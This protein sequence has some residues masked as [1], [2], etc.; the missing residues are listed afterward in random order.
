[1]RSRIVRIGNSKGIRIPKALLEEAQLKDE[2][3]ITVE[4]GA[5]VVRPVRRVRE[6]WAEAARQAHEAGED[7]LL[8]E[9]TPLESDDTDWVWE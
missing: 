1:M 4:N 5:L 3:D 6:G 2:V 7:V 9:Y 8:D